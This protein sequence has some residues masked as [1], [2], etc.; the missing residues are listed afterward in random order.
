MPDVIAK[1]FL[2]LL[3][4]EPIFFLQN[5]GFVGLLAWETKAFPSTLPRTV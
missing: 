3:R 1:K 4:L 5:A 2:E